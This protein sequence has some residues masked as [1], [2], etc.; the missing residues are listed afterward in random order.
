MVYIVLSPFGHLLD[1]S[2]STYST[3]RTVLCSLQLVRYLFGIRG[4][5]EVQLFDKLAIFEDI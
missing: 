1:R 5:I 4:N 3:I 2:F